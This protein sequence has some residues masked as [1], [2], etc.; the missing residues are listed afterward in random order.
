MDCCLK[1]TKTSHIMCISNIL[2][3]LCF[4]KQKIK[5]KNTFAS[6]FY[7]ALVVKM[8]WQSIKKFVWALMV[9]NEFKNYFKQIP[10]P[11]KSSIYADFECN[12]K[13]VESYEGSY[14]KKYKDHIPYSFVYKLVCVDDN[15]SKIVVCRGENVASKF[16]K[17]ILRGYE[18]WEK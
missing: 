2:T 7:S 6:V 11:F 10:V 9:H 5:T 12:L 17:A 16:I 18:Y 1:L 15:F 14:S 3:N 4:T 8:Y 13:S